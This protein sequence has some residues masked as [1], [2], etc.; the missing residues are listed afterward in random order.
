[1]GKK[2]FSII[3]DVHMSTLLLYYGKTIY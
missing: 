3:V 2:A 1:M